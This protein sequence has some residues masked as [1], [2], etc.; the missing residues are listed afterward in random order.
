MAK[1]GILIKVKIIFTL[2]KRTFRNNIKISLKV[3]INY[4]RKVLDTYTF[5]VKVKS[6]S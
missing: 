6:I 5:K 3:E 2:Q 4:L 1:F